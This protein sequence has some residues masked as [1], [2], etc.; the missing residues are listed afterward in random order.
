ML[1]GYL[2][3]LSL[4]LL[5]KYGKSVAVDVEAISVDGIVIFSVRGAIEPGSRRK[6]PESTMKWTLPNVASMSLRSPKGAE[7][8]ASVCGVNSRDPQRIELL[9]LDNIGADGIGDAGEE[10]ADKIG[11]AD[12]VPCTSSFPT[13]G[14]N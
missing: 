11:A 6:P 3:L 1:P 13:D 14:A 5:S 9:E 10:V 8:N 12:E 4:L 2:W 7:R